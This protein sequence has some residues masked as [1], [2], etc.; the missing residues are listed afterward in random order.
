[1]R[2]TL[3]RCA[4]MRP[5]APAAAGAIAIAARCG[6]VVT[7]GAC[8]TARRWLRRFEE[9][10]GRDRRGLARGGDHVAERHVAGAQAIGIDEHLKLAIALAPDRHVGDAGNRHQPRPDRPLRQRRQLDLRQRLRGHADLHHPAERRQRRQDDRRMRGGREAGGDARAGAPARAGARD[11]RSVPSSK[12]STTDDSPSTDFER[13]VFRPGTPFIAVF[14]RHGDERLDFCGREARAPRSGSRRAA[15][16]TPGRRRTARPA[17]PGFR[18]RSGR[19][20]APRPAREAATP[21]R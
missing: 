3:R 1:M 18:R 8:A 9:P 2:R 4:K 17:P 7:A 19:P 11:M 10:A 15:A 13:S 6:A 21:R 12:I 5:V 14:E 20:T 16:R